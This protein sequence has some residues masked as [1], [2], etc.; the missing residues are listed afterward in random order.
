VFGAYAE[1]YERWRPGY[2]AAAVDWLVPPGAARVADVGAGTGKL[3]GALLAR[4]LQV[5]AV[6]PDPGM[7][8]VLTRLHPGA[9]P[10]LAGAQALPLP[11]TS[12][13][14][15]LVAQAWHWFPHQQAV[16]EVR[17]VLRPGGWLALVWN[18][19]HPREPWELELASL[20]PDN[21]GRDVA[22]DRRTLDVAGLPAGELETAT[23][24]WTWPVSAADLRARLATH[25]A[26]VVMDA[27]QRERRLGAAAAVVAA[28]ARRRGTPTVQL[29]QVAGCV[30]WQPELTGRKAGSRR[31]AG[32]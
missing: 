15:V 2:P 21:A 25:S 6:E 26:F 24:P 13:D 3:T 23:F 27:D 22:A 11:D 5:A 29:R 19:P 31:E 10:Y 17:R 14:A 1:D 4:G 18:G 30:R 7:L 20:D 16:A 32:R 9:D 28:E 12:L 8:A